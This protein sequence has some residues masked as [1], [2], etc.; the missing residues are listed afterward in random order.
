V[1]GDEVG[2]RGLEGQDLH[3]VLRPRTS[4]WPPVEEGAASA[5]GDPFL[6]APEVVD[7]AEVHV[8]HPRSRGDG[9]RDGE[10]GN[11]SLRVQA[12]VDRVEDDTSSLAAVAEH[13]LAELL[14]N[15]RE[16][17]SVRSQLLEPRYDSGLRGR[18]HGRRLVPSLAPAGSRL[19]L[20]PRGQLL[21]D[22][23][24]GPG[25]VPADG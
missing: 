21:E 20:S 9:D 17:D 7:V 18:V 19:A 15:E 12:S 10:E 5:P 11:P 14:G 22:T 6:A 3:L 23:A 16:A 8:A 24:D 13:P 1:L 25:R 4:E 2:T